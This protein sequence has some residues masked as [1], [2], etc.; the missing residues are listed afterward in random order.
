MNPSTAFTQS[1]CIASSR[2]NAEYAAEFDQSSSFSPSFSSSKSAAARRMRSAPFRGCSNKPT[3]RVGISYTSRKI[4]GHV[5]VRFV[6]HNPGSTTFTITP[7]S[8]FRIFPSAYAVIISLL[9]AYLTP[10]VSKSFSFL[11]LAHRSR[12]FTHS[13]AFARVHTPSLA[14]CV[15][16]PTN[17]TF[18]FLLS[19]FA[20]SSLHNFVKTAG[21]RTLH[22]ASRSTPPSSTNTTFLSA[23]HSAAQ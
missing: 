17:T 14:R 19:S 23:L 22:I 8:S 13:L 21:P 11:S 3:I 12:R 4:F 2:A 10:T 18:F 20:I 5:L 1:L 6:R 7:S 9:N 16:D 15:N